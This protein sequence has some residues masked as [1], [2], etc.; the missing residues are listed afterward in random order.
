M[1]LERARLFAF[2]AVLGLHFV[3]RTAAADAVDDLK[4][5]AKSA[6]EP[7][8]AIDASRALRRAGLYTDAATVVQRALGKAR[9]NDAIADLRL[10]LAR[11]YI[12]ERQSK[13]ALR[14][15]DQIHKASPL[16]EQVCIAEAQL[17]G[18]RGSIALP[19]A[20]QALALSPGEYDAL[21]AKGRALAQIGKPA[22]AEAALREASRAQPARAP[23]FRFLGELYLAQ[24]RTDDA[25][26]ALREA[27][28][29]APDEPDVLVL[30]G[31][32]LPPGK[33]AREAL[34]HAL[35]I[36]GGDARAR[37]RL[38]QVL[39]ALG[40]Y[41]GAE[42]MLEQALAAEPRQADW[43]AALGDVE[44]AQKK[45]DL[46]LK[47]AHAALKIAANHGPAKL[48]E[49]KALADKGEIDLA[50]EAF[51]AA[52]GLM[53]TDPMPLVDAARACVKGGRLT[54]AKAFADRATEDFPNS[55]LAWETT[56]DIDVAQKDKVAARQA[57]DKALSSDGTADKDAIRKKIASL[58]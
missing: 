23:A 6:S 44:L 49:A 2:T 40:D 22:E 13:K 3:G 48:V 25:L 41:D 51:E 39:A 18:R 16:K 54:T 53:R 28:R 21:V 31:Q 8:E 20:E 4:A 32:A 50:I 56:G 45:P 34:E 10:E 36:R 58:K 27:R 55:S 33:E 12:D 42:K 9:G 14:E 17:L 30:L 47:S 43:H 46:A 5:R 26:A 24:G 19:A 38:G 29:V 1:S 15:C 52:Y 35:A 57:Y 7:G 37:A 11:T